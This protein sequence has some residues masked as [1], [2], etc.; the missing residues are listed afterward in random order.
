MGGWPSELGGSYY[1]QTQFGK[2]EG[3]VPEV[4]LE[5]EKKLQE[6]LISQIESGKNKAAHDLSEG[7]L[8]VCLSEML[9]NGKNLVLLFPFHLKIHLIVSMLFFSGKVRG[10]WLWQSNP[11]IANDF[12]SSCQNLQDVSDRFIGSN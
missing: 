9:F 6:F 12:I 11:E 1:L 10:G 5:N 2:K 4:N 3:S 7:G 8:L